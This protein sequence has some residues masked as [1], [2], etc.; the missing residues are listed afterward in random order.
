RAPEGRERGAGRGRPALPGRGRGVGARGGR[1]P[2]DGLLEALGPVP[3]GSTVAVGG[4]GLVRKPMG[5]RRA[6]AASGGRDL[7]LVSVLGSAGVELLLA[8]GCVAELPSAGVSL[9][10][11]GLAPRY[12]A[13]RERGDVRFVEWSE[14]ALL[15]ALDAASLD[16]DSSLTRSGLG[17]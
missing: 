4:A 1:P 9:D 17:T 10:A 16:L 11:V 6:P 7:V 15:A 12:R 2:V 8:A 5:L 13:A 3:A 14:G